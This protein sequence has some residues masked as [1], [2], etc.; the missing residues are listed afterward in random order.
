MHGGERGVASVH[1][2]EER[3]RFGT[4]DFPD[5][6]V[7]RPLPHGGTEEIEHID[8]VATLGKRIAGDACDP[9]VVIERDL[10]CVLDADNLCDRRNKERNG[11]ERSG[12]PGCSP[13]DEEQAHAVFYGQ[14][15]IG[16]FVARKRA[17]LHE[18]DR[19]ERIFPELP[20][21]KRGATGGYLGPKRELETGAVRKGRI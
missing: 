15:E 21:G 3:L 12:L 2:L 9:V 11:V 17:V 20:D 1:R 10:P 7:L 8:G 13:A 14:P 16:K 18:L 6:D 4:T 5:N 19:R